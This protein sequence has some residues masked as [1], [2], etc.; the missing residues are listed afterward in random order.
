MNGTKIG[1]TNIQMK[2]ENGEWVKLDDVS[3]ATL[4]IGE[5]TEY[6]RY[7][8]LD[9]TKPSELSIK[10]RAKR[11]GTYIEK[12]LYYQ[13]SKKKRIRKKWDFLRNV[14]GIRRNNGR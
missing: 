9:A 8:W 12:C 14:F 11:K 2:N 10:I 13:K 5:N 4:S 6:D 3:E 1:L 7:D